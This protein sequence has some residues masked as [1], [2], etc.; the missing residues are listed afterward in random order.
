MKSRAVYIN[1]SIRL[2]EI[3]QK[4]GIEKN[5]D[6]LQRYVFELSE[7][8]SEELDFL[9]KKRFSAA[10]FSVI[11]TKSPDTVLLKLENASYISQSEN[12]NSG[13]S[14]PV[15]LKDFFQGLEKFTIQDSR[16]VW[17]FSGK[18]LD[19]NAAPIIMGI[20]NITP[21][22]FSDGGKYLEKEKAVEHAL[23]MAEQGAQII[24]IGGEST[25]PGADPVSVEDEIERTVPVIQEIRRHSNVIIS[26]DTYKSET[27]RRALDAGVDII[28]DISGLQFDEKMID[29]AREAGCPVIVMHIKGTP[30]NMQKDPYYDDAVQEIYHYF[31]E[32]I[33]FL[34]NSGI[35]KIIIDPGIGFGK[36]LQDNLV[37]IRDL[38]DFRFLGK[39]L[40]AGLSRKSFIG[41][42]LD[43]ETEE[44]LAGTV[45]ASI[46]SVLKGA[47]IIR[48]HDVDEAA[49]SVEVLKAVH[50]LQLEF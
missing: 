4:Y 3:Q 8:S 20:V 47:E 49:D 29:T 12:K 5:P 14:A 50:N 22:S 30:R 23:K 24:D 7:L 13:E 16:P 26:I 48:V 19:F 15:S 17:E 18:V 38:M 28:N 36:R 33:T 32:R 42:I 37:L 21:D 45:T 27:A 25:R 34:E 46:I 39:P 10:E 6:W 11:K 9:A 44:R 1:D 2:T 40:M 43:A 41:Q 31:E 35:D